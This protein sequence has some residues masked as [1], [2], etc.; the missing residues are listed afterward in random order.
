MLWHGVWY[1]Q[2]QPHHLMVLQRVPNQAAARYRALRHPQIHL[3]FSFHIHLFN[4]LTL[5]VF[6]VAHP[7]LT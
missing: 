6:Q 5:L 2:L 3:E 4:L 1:I 7:F